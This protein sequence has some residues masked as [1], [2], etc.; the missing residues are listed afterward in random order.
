MLTVPIF[1]TDLEKAK[2]FY[3]DKLLFKITEYSPRELK[4]HLYIEGVTDNIRICITKS[5]SPAIH[6][7]L[8]R[9]EFFLYFEKTDVSSIY[10]EIKNLIPEFDSPTDDLPNGYC[11]G[12][13]ECPGGLYMTIY[14]PFGN[15]LEFREW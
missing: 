9:R 3:C 13:Y 8:K 2:E 11:S 5:A 7:I 14:D 15:R 4:T 10:L 1:V 6:E 12:I